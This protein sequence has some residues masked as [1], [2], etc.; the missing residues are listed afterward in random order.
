VGAVQATAVEHVLPVL[1]AFP[2]VPTGLASLPD[3]DGSPPARR[4]VPKLV[5]NL[6]VRQRTTRTAQVPATQ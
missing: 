1:R 2:A 4:V 6:V 3:P 5:W